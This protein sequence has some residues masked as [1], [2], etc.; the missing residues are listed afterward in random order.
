M[1]WFLLNACFLLISA[2][3]GTCVL[4]EYVF[5]HQP[6]CPT[7]RASASLLLFVILER[8]KWVEATVSC[9]WIEITELQ[10]GQES[11]GLW[12][13]ALPSTSPSPTPP[14]PGFPFRVR[15]GISCPEW[16]CTQSSHLVSCSWAPPILR[17][18]HALPHLLTAFL[19]VPLQPRAP[20]RRSNQNAACPLG[21][22][23]GGTLQS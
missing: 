14:S 22:F 21:T 11:L 3:P 12:V 1:S 16:K 19:P 9:L 10:K 23:L 5:G 15:E 6:A 20:P 18:S 8:V 7:R 13:L 4:V 2:V 17:V